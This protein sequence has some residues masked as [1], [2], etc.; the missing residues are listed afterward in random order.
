M[1]FLAES[2]LV[3]SNDTGVRNMGIS[4]GANTL[5]IFYSTVPYRYWPRDGK[6]EVVFNA[7]RSIPEVSKVYLAT[8]EHLESLR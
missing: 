1:K 2:S 6:H 7:D 8:K 3:V 5:G 4:I